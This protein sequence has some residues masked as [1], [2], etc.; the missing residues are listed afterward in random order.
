MIILVGNTGNLPHKYYAEEKGPGLF[1]KIIIR[2]T[3]QIKVQG[4]AAAR[5]IH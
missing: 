3:R 2:T 5:E 4:N 1:L